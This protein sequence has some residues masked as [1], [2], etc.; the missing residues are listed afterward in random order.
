[1][2]RSNSNDD[3]AEA[4]TLA[5]DDIEDNEARLRGEIDLNDADEVEYYFEYGEDEDD[6][7]ERTDLSETTRDGIVSERVTGLDEDTRYF[8]RL[9]IEDTDTGEEDE[10]SIRN[11]RT[12]D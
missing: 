12:D 8:F 11:F 7:D 2:I 5:A 4:D 9:V 10:G 6:L 3:E 1:M